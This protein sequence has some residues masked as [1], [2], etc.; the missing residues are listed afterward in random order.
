MCG[1]AVNLGKW[2][3]RNL[4]Q[5][6]TREEQHAHAW[7]LRAAGMSPS[8]SPFRGTGNF[9]AAPPP[10][11]QR[12]SA[13]DARGEA[14]ATSTSSMVIVAPDMLPALSQNSSFDTPD[15]QAQ[16]ALPPS[17]SPNAPS[18]GDATLQHQ[19]QLPVPTLHP[20]VQSDATTTTTPGGQDYFGPRVV[21]S[22]GSSTTPAPAPTTPEDPSGSGTGGQSQG[23]TGPAASTPG[24][25]LMGKL[26]G[27]GRTT[28]RVASES[29]PNT[30]GPPSQARTPSAAAAAAATVSPA[31]VTPSARQAPPQEPP[32]PA[33][34][35]TAAVAVLATGPL[36]PP[37]ATDGPALPL[38]PDI[39][40]LVAEERA[41]GWAIVYRGTVASVGNADDVE[42]LE[43][44]MP[45]WLLEYLLLG[46]TPQVA[47][48]KIGFV[49]LPIQSGM[50][51]EELPEL[52]NT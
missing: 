8:P 15:P 50:P 22:S 48:V 19:Q 16:P 52:V 30:P 10:P 47:V 46:R 28:K 12:N 38:A 42:T 43:D 17:G 45:I 27:L 41:H 25:G 13:E 1:G 44:V 6:F 34:T 40:L 39:P 31:S 26:R 14:N 21:S 29:V 7:R 32:P 51:G 24:G 4:F 35:R 9:P 20:R 33:K 36:N 23:G 11:E 49:L 5:G 37:T 3:L 18:I 2:I